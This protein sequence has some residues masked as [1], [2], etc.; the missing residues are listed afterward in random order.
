MIGIYFSGTGNSKYALEVFL[1][2]YGNDSV[3]FSIE[4]KNLA[5]QIKSQSYLV[6][7]FNI[8]QCPNF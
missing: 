1:R 5:E 8:V 2:E 7:L 3:L 4:D 6:I